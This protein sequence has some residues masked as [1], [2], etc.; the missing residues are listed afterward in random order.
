MASEDSTSQQ[1]VYSAYYITKEDPKFEKLWI[2]LRLL[3]DYGVE[4]L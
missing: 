1:F 4:G 2:L 3:R